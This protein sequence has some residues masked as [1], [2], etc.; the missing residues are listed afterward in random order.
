MLTDEAPPAMQL[1]Q[2]KWNGIHKQK[3]N[4]QIGD[5]R[6]Y[7]TANMLNEWIRTINIIKCAVRY[8]KN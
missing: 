3:V 5:L 1:K 4:Y 8:V 7:H 6:K 2:C